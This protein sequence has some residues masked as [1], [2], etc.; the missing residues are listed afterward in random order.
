MKAQRLRRIKGG[1]GA[2]QDGDCMPNVAA[3]F[4]KYRSAWDRGG[5]EGKSGLMDSRGG[6]VCR[7]L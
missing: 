1:A 7:D 3:Q 5:W 4:R 2:A 6:M